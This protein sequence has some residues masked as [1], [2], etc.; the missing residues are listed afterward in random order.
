METSVY[1]SHLQIVRLGGEFQ[2]PYVG[3]GTVHH[4][5]VIQ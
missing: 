3:G 4:R 2:N 5:V 1:R